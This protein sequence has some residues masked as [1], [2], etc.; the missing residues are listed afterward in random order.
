MLSVYSRG[1]HLAPLSV[2]VW[3]AATIHVFAQVS[4]KS[5]QR[6]CLIIWWFVFGYRVRRLCNLRNLSIARWSYIY[7]YMPYRLLGKKASFS[8]AFS[9][10]RF[11]Y[12]ALIV[13][14]SIHSTVGRSIASISN[15]SGIFTLALRALVNMSL[16]VWYISYRPPSRTVYIT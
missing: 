12:C 16:R 14:Y 9:G 15:L 11:V 6:T 3:A 2:C 4:R 1:R 10:K 7:I 5:M 13:L 8:E